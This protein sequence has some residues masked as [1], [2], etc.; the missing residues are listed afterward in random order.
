MKLISSL[1]LAK[2][3]FNTETW[4]TQLFN[5]EFKTDQREDTPHFIADCSNTSSL[6]HELMFRKQAA[7]T[8][9]T[10]R[11]KVHRTKV[12]ASYSGDIQ[13]MQS[14]GIL[15]KESGTELIEL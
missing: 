15:Q 3:N 7:R 10:N 11:T 8:Q 13:A 2:E 12:T 6:S 1:N 14:T 9:V 5:S 4:C